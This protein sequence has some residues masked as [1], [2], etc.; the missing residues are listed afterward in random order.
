[1]ATAGRVLIIPRGDYSETYTYEMLDM[2]NY[3][4]GTWLAK[5]T[6]LGAVPS[7]GSELWFKMFDNK[8]LLKDFIKVIKVT[9][10]IT[11]PANSKVLGELDV[12][13]S[14]PSGYKAVSTWFMT[15]G[16]DWFYPIM[17]TINTASNILGYSVKNT[18]TSS[19]SGKPQFGVL[20][21]KII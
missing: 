12:T 18:Y 20:C 4:G 19:D 5:Q 6:S 16:S 3:K 7:E 9:G 2:V 17:C 11:A 14:I 21:V 1:M 13:D 8:D 10:N 15:S